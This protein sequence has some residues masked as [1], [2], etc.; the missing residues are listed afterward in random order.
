[1]RRLKHAS[2]GF[3][4]PDVRLQQTIV[5]DRCQHGLAR[6]DE[7][8]RTRLDPEDHSVKGRL[9][10][11][12]IELEGGELAVGVELQQRRPRLAALG[13]QCAGVFRNPVASLSNL[14]LEPLDSRFESLHRRLCLLQLELGN[15]CVEGKQHLAFLHTLARLARDFL[16]RTSGL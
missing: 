5:R 16:D 1:M 10:P 13:V 8:S 4:D 15:A 14:E 9:N 3:L 7:V 11:G 2:R 12:R 6:L